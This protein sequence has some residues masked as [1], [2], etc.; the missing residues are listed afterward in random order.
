MI[1]QLLRAKRRR[2]I[3]DV[4]TQRDL[5][6]AEGKSCIRNHRRVL[7][8]IRRVMAWARKKNLRI[9]STVGCSENNN[10]NGDNN[11]ESRNGQRKIPYTLLNR[12][13]SFIADGSTDIPQ[14]VLR[15]YKQVVFSKRT[16]DPFAEPRIERLL[17]EIQAE[18]FV[19]IGSVAEASVKSMV[20]GLLQRQ[21]KVCVIVDAVGSL[22]KRKAELAIRQMEAKGAKL[23]EAK[24]LAGSTHLKQVR[25]CG[26]DRCRGKLVTA[27]AQ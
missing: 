12:R 26:C 27:A 24:K 10:G 15:D 16:V 13:I 14:N 1:L 9:I 7:V 2:V 22:N 3:I 4:D 8:N 21:K 5:L 19:V 23:I 20:L 6:L 18:E 11:G 25:M 17:S